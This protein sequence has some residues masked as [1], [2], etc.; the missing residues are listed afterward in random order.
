MG[1]VLGAIAAAI[2]DT[3]A[4]LDRERF[5]FP[6]RPKPIPLRGAKTPAMESSVPDE[7]RKLISGDP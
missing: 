6:P 4:P 3:T 7:R 2:T 1:A 5:P